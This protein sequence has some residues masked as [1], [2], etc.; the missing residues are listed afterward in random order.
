MA[1]NLHGMETVMT[2]CF[3]WSKSAAGCRCQDEEG[4]KDCIDVRVVTI[5]GNWCQVP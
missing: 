3:I 1:I 5:P 2:T 4:G